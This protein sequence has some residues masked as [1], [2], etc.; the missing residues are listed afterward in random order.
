MQPTVYIETSVVSYLTARPS[1]DL[2]VAGHQQITQDWWDN[3][4][5]KVQCVISPSVIEE[6]KRGDEKAAEERLNAIRELPVLAVNENVKELALEYLNAIKIPE[7]AKTDAFH[8]AF[9]AWYKV[10][11]LL[12]WNCKHIASGRVRKILETINNKL[13]IHTPVFVHRKN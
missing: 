10:D 9:P 3:I 12:T 8:L 7:K 2:I 13:N 11:Y 6:A 5:P 4:R 1:R